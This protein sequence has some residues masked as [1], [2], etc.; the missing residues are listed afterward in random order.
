MRR[1]FSWAFE[2]HARYPRG[3]N[4]RV[5]RIF[6]GLARASAPGYSVSD[7]RRYHDVDVTAVRLLGQF[8]VRWLKNNSKSRG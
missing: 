5:N 8:L 7:L 4:P 6:A 3:S 2:E 1:S